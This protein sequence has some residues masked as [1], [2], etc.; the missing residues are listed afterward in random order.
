[1]KKKHPLDGCDFVADVPRGTPLLVQGHDGR[2]WRLTRK[3][4]RYHEDAATLLHGARP[5]RAPAPV[6]AS[7]RIRVI[8]QSTRGGQLPAGIGEAT[9][10][11]HDAPRT[12]GSTADTGTLWVYPVPVGGCWVRAFIPFYDEAPRG[13]ARQLTPRESAQL[14]R[15]LAL[16]PRGVRLP[17]VRVEER[18]VKIHPATHSAADVARAPVLKWLCRDDLPG[19]EACDE[20]QEWARARGEG[21]TLEELYRQ[22]PRGDWLVWGLFR[23]G[24][25][26]RELSL[27]VRP[28]VLRALRVYAPAALD[29]AV[30]AG[31]DPAL[32][33]H[34]RRLRALPAEISPRAAAAAARAVAAARASAAEASRAAAATR[35]AAAAAR[36]AAAAARWAAAAADA[37]STD[38]AGWTAAAAAESAGWAAAGSAAEHQ[39]CADEVRVAFPWTNVVQCDVGEDEVRPDPLRHSGRVARLD[40]GR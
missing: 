8:L 26:A 11:W 34:A 19:G 4:V 33:E 17:T 6:A 21:A 22:C 27:A 14:A 39:R 35:W 32:A 16:A 23:A 9:A 29:A 5:A 3:G 10:V 36:W 24:V 25:P 40:G 15:D 38:A 2:V 30:A 12:Q 1:M 31:A 13:G 37:A 7:D 28:S 18:T 20:V